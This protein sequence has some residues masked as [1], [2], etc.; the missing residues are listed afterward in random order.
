MQKAR[1]NRR[2]AREAAHP[3]N[4]LRLDER[5]ARS[6][7]DDP[8]RSQA[9]AELTASIKAHGLLENLIVVPRGK[10]LYGVAAPT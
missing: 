8:A 4:K 5:N 10:R 3:L 2:V 9:D 6:A 1:R 7:S